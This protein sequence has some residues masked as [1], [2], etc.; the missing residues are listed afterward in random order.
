MHE[1][2]TRCFAPTPRHLV[3]GG[4]ALFFLGTGVLLAAAL[5]QLVPAAS[6]WFLPQG[7]LGYTAAATL[8]C[9]GVWAMGAGLRQARDAAPRTAP[10]RPP[11][12]R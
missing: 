7:P 2:I 11:Q 1:L 5:A 6:A 10:V 4:L 9:W 8:V 12:V 3:R